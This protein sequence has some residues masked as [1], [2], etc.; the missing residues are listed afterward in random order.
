MKVIFVGR[1]NAFNRRIVEEFSAEHEVLCCLFVETERSSWKGKQ[2]KISGR[3]KKYG[4]IKVLDELAFHAFDRFFLRTK[5]PIFWKTQPEYCNNSIPLS[6]PVYKVDNINSRK[7]TEFCGSLSPDIIL[8]TC[9]HIIFKPELYNTPALGT[10]VIHE[11]LTP[12]YKGLHTPLWALMKKEFQYIGYTVF[13]VNDK[14]DGGEILAQGTYPISECECYKKW[15]WIGH[16][17][18]ISGLVNIRQSFKELEKKRYFVPVD[19]ANR[20]SGYYT[21]MSLSSFIRLRLK[22]YNS[23]QKSFNFLN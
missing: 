15:S 21:W 8:A 18:I 2:E 20:K 4:L 11:G 16:N 10:Y 5:E 9:S 3:I 6:C 14:I 1:D 7:W 12:E 23:L 13:K 17:A 22:N 19:T